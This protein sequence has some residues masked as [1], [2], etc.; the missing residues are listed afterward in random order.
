MPTLLAK[1][2][3]I[4]RELGMPP[5]LGLSAALRTALELTGLVAEQ[6]P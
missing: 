1:V 2:T 6:A 4:S 5:T 3:A